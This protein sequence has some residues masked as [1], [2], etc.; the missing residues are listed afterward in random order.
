MTIPIG[1]I[2]TT[3]KILTTKPIEGKDLNEG[4]SKHMKNPIHHLLAYAVLGLL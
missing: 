3:I 1:E 2:G 4:G